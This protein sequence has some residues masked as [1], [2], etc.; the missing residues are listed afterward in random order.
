MEQHKLEITLE[1]RD[2]ER[3][4]KLSERNGEPMESLVARFLAADLAKIF[5]KP[6]DVLLSERVKQLS[7]LHRS[8]SELTSFEER[9]L[10]DAYSKKRDW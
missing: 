8:N 3:L 4:Q 9:Y 10:T 5:N 7:G 2:W 6:P 1:Q